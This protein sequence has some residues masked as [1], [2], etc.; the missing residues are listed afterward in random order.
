MLAGSDSSPLDSELAEAFVELLGRLATEVEMTARRFGLP[1]FCVKALH[2]LGSPLAMKEVGQRFHCDPSFVTAIADELGARGLAGRQPDPRDRR[3]KRLTL[4]PEGIA[5]RERIER[6]L[7]D[8]M[9]WAR[10]LDPAERERLL[11]LLRK[12]TSAGQEPP[13]PGNQ[14]ECAGEVTAQAIV[15][16]PASG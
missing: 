14:G 5:L 9:P 7:A 3:V 4:T 10:A 1:T 12:M 13:A 2:M 8:R 6:E 11:G 16:A 15:A